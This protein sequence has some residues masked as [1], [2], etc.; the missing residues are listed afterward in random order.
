M[1]PQKNGQAGESSME[2]NGNTNPVLTCP[3]CLTEHVPG[4]ANCL[5]CGF[6]FA[7][8]GKTIKFRTSGI[9]AGAR[10]RP[11]GGLSAPP[12]IKL[13]FEIAGNTL[14]LPQMDALI[15]GRTNPGDAGPDVDLGK[16]D[17]ANFGVSR[18]HVRISRSHNLFHLCD[19]GSAN[20]TFLNGLKLTPH[21]EN[22]LHDGDELRLSRLTVKL[23]FKK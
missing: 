14:V 12:Q 3:M 13:A 1:Y 9:L 2:N 4:T 10:K 6:D 15:I 8:V 18:L 7:M 16:F 11:V 21:Q 20:G 22:L 17:A 23:R 19:L 5:S